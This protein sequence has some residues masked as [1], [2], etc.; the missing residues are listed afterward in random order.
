VEN[1]KRILVLARWPVGG[2]RTYFRYIY[3]QDLFVGYHFTFLMPNT[4]GIKDLLTERISA[5]RHSF[6]DTNGEGLFKHLY[7]TLKF[8]NFDVIHSHGFTAGLTASIFRFIFK[9]PHLLTT[10]DVLS[11]A[12][13][14][15]VKGLVQKLGFSLLFKSVNKVMPVGHDAASNLLEFYPSL[16]NKVCP[17]RNGIPTQYFFD[18]IPRDIKSEIGIKSDVFLIGFFGRFMAQKGFRYLVDAVEKLSRD[19]SIPNFKVVCF[20]WGGFIR[21]DQA[22]LKF[23]GL[24]SYFEFMPQTND[25][26]SALK[27]VDVVAMPSLWEACPLLPMEAL[28]AGVPIIGTSCIGSREVF[29]GSPAQIVEPKDSIALAQKIKQEMITPTK[30]EFKRYAPIAVETFSSEKCA[31][32]LRHVYEKFFKH[33]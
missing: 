19:T 20:G 22:E 5:D 10:H 23:R 29:S 3:S 6:I 28:C 8:E 24:D 26:P 1:K 21:E 17:V 12:Q 32:E 13:F 14:K 2:I 11:A 33:I 30:K 31:D 4:D 16:K 15:G 25:M 27:G 18:G 9:T 7:E